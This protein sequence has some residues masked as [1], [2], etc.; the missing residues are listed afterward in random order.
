MSPGSSL[1]VIIGCGVRIQMEL[2]LKGALVVFL[3]GF[4]PGFLYAFFLKP[5]GFGGALLT[6]T[7][8]GGILLGLVEMVLSQ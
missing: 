5:A 7:F 3:V 6:A 8:I 2:T 1:G 4:V